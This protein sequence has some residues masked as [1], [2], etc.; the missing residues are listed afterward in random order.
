MTETSR[1]DRN[2]Q[3]KRERIFAAAAELFSQFPC[4]DVTTQQVADR[5]DVAIG[6][7]FRYAATKGELILMVNN[8]VWA[9]AIDAGVDRARHMSDVADGLFALALPTLELAIAQPDTTYAYQRE[10]MFGAPDEQFRSEGERLVARFIDHAAE[11]LAGPNAGRE[12]H[13]AGQSVFAV[14]HLAAVRATRAPDGI[15]ETARAQLTQLAAGFSAAHHD[16]DH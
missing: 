10:L 1:R 12:A 8:D 15:I 7:L 6:T 13:V 11:I 9:R 2:T 5:A 14:V 16:A 4:D 3:A